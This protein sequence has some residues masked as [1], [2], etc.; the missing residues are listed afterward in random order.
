MCISY[1]K[2]ISV[3]SYIVLVWSCLY[4]VLIAF[5][6]KKIGMANKVFF[7]LINA[8]VI[9]MMF[10]IAPKNKGDGTEYFRMSESLFNHLS[11]DLQPVDD[12]TLDRDVADWNFNFY[13]KIG[14]Y[15]GKNGKY[16]SYHFWGYSLFSLPVK[17]IIKFFNFN[18]FKVFQIMNAFFLAFALYFIVF[19]SSFAELQRLL[20]S[21]MVVFSPAFWFI[22]WPSPEI[23]SYSLVV[24]SLVCLYGNRWVPA[25][26]FSAIAASQNPP[27]FLLTLFCGFNGVLHSKK[28]IKEIFFVVLAAS[29]FIVSVVYYYSSFG[30]LNKVADISTNIELISFFRILDLFFDYNLGVIAYLPVIFIFY[31]ILLCKECATVKGFSLTKQ[32]FVV[33]IMMVLLSTSSS[34]WNH[35]TSWISRYAVWILPFMFFSIVSDDGFRA[36]RKNIYCLIFFISMFLEISLVF[37]LGGFNAP[38]KYDIHNR[39]ARLILNNYPQFYNP[40]IEIFAERTV[41]REGIIETPVIY[42]NNDKCKKVLAKAQDEKLIVEKCAYIPEKYADFF[43]KEDSEEKAIYVNY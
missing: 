33:M 14:Y 18:P 31:I 12:A 16:Y 27:I 22:R 28:K 25:V 1:E 23:F 37:M 36:K 15:E 5:S 6:E 17:S 26:F 40:D 32:L 38:M 9:L 30:V 29:P 43:R 41:N 34:N 39:L 21:F 10:L 11:P 24:T 42:Y 2:I 13:P 7:F 19:R 3:A 4:V 35:G 20:L 8:I